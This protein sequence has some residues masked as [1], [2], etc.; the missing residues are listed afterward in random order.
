MKKKKIFLA[1]VRSKQTDLS[2]IIII[3]WDWEREREG[4]FL[5]SDS[6]KSIKKVNAWESIMAQTSHLV[7]S[8]S[9]VDYLQ[10]SH[11]RE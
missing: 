11:A 2:I 9:R 1:F 5:N 4:D 10:Y 3:I 7:T 8:T 6:S